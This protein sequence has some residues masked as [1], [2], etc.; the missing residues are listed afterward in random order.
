M[1]NLL[2][3]FKNY[4]I[5]IFNTVNIDGY[6]PFVWKLLRPSL[7]FKSVM[8]PWDQKCWELLQEDI[9]YF[10]FRCGSEK[11]EEDTIIS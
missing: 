1:V 9:I 7:L 4:S 2:K 6:N 5:F 10:P 3:H 8:G 11:S